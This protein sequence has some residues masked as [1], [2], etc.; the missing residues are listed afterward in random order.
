[1]VAISRR[2]QIYFRAVAAR[3]A[4]I[5]F[6]CNEGIALFIRSDLA[7]YPE[8]DVGFSCSAEVHRKFPDELKMLHRTGETHFK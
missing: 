1:M 7:E 8:E 5:Q 6:D 3:K 2:Q 4:P